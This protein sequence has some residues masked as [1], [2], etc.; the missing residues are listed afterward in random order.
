VLAPRADLDQAVSDRRE[1]SPGERS[2]RRDRRAHAMHQPERGGAEDEWHLIGCHAVTL[3]A[4]AGRSCDRLQRAFTT[5]HHFCAAVSSCRP[6]TGSSQR[7]VQ[8]RCATDRVM[9]AQIVGGLRHQG[10]ERG[11]AGEVA[12]TALRNGACACYGC[13]LT[14]IRPAL[15]SLSTSSYSSDIKGVASTAISHRRVCAIVGVG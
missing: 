2:G 7:W 10:V 15:E 1:L 5:S 4:H 14:S 8:L 13:T 11:V 3:L 12:S 6:C 9:E